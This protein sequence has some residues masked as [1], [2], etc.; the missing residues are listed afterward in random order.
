MPGK[1]PRSVS[2]GHT[3]TTAAMGAWGQ[4]RDSPCSMGA[5]RFSR[6]QASH[7]G[8]GEGREADVEVLEALRPDR[9]LGIHGAGRTDLHLDLT[10]L[11]GRRLQPLQTLLPTRT[12]ERESDMYTL[13]GGRDH[14][15]A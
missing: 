11:H 12:S 10:P 14:R 15:G 3:A 6:G 7:R 1:K 2:H 8:V 5:A 13:Y 9:G 4:H